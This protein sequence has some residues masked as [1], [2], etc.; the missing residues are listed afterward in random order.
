MI[1][2]KHCDSP[3]LCEEV[4]PDISFRD[5][6]FTNRGLSYR[7]LG[8]PR[9]GRWLERLFKQAQLW[10]FSALPRHRGATASPVSISGY[11]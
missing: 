5:R 3:L 4:M 9:L 7:K 8:H 10:L 6:D 11:I 2:G 1:T